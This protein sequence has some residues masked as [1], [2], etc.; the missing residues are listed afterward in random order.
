MRLFA[1]RPALHRFDRAEEFFES[2]RVGEG[3]LILTNRWILPPERTPAGSAVLYQEDAGSGEPTDKMLAALLCA[4]GDRRRV[5]G[6]GG[7][8]VLDLAKLLSLAIDK[9]TDLYAL[10]THKIPAASAC[11]CVLAPT[12]CGTGSEVTNVSVLLFTDLAMKVGLA[13][14]AL[15]AR[16]A[17]LIPEFLSSLPYP[18]FAFSSIDALIHAVESF[19]SPRA[20]DLTRLFS[21]QAIGEILS[22]YTT[23]EPG[24]LPDTD[25]LSRLL[26][27]STCAGIAFGNAGCGAV[28]AMSYP[29]GGKYHLPH[30][31]SNYLLFGAV[32]RHY[33]RQAEKEPLR[34]LCRL[35]A[36]SLRCRPEEAL[37]ALSALLSRVWPRKSLSQAGMTPEDFETFPAQVFTRQQRLLAGAMCPLT[38]ADLAAIYRDADQ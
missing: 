38:E 26:T 24:A 5:I 8:T 1:C 21:R 3:D 28:H 11:P 7:G 23:M 33:D 19:L 32:L 20:T 4:A 6:I 35:I 17:V 9:D 36:E 18:A 14:E 31:E 12:T 2:F 37:P 13:D 29:L 27:A 10:F 30:G 15:Y 22:V 25:A 34:A 16:E